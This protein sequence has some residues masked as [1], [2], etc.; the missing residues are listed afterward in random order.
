MDSS[1]ELKEAKEILDTLLGYLGFF[2]TIEEE[3]SH[4]GRMLQVHT[5]DA[6]IL[7]GRRGDRLDDIQYLVNRLLQSKDEEHSRVRIDIGHY[8]SQQEQE[9]VEKIKALAE[10]VRTTGRAIRLNPLN[11]YHRRIV[12]N[13]LKDDP[14]VETSSPPER[15][16]M[17]RITIRLRE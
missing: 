4:E 14:S 9:M 11:S 10:R 7:I 5:E 3:D 13:V 12:H 1:T 17:K 6:P 15:A 2:V 16:R 8:R